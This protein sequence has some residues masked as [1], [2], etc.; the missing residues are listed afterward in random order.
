MEATQCDGCAN[1]QGKDD[2]GNLVAVG[3]QVD[4][5]GAEE[6]EEG[7]PPGDAVDDD[8]L[9]VVSEPVDDRAEQQQMNEG[10]DEE[11][12]WCGGE[13]GLPAR[14]VHVGGGS[15]GGDVRPEE[16]EVNDYVQNL[17]DLR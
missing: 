15:N 16:E 13:V 11:C 5:D 10:L 4:V 17:R 6:S 9:A 3:P 8:R 7:E 2:G 14:V 1:E 12:P